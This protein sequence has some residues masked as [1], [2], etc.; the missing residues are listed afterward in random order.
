MK[1]YLLII[2]CIIFSY[3]LSAKRNIMNYVFVPDSISI[4][5]RKAYNDITG[6]DSVGAE[7]NVHNLINYKNTKWGNGVFSFAGMGPHFPHIVFIHYNSKLY[8]ISAQTSTGILKQ[9]I[10]AQEKLKIPNKEYLLYLK[11]IINYIYESYM[12]KDYYVS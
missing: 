10:E 5:L 11:K 2:G 8:M 3:S 1:K 4:K 7:I 9:L 6:C 12:A